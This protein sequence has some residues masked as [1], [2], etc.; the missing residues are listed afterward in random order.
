MNERSNNVIKNAV[1]DEAMLRKGEREQHGRFHLYFI[2][3]P[4]EVV[5]LE[6]CSSAPKIEDGSLV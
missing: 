4:D 3:E 6:S 1:C 2:Q 5:M